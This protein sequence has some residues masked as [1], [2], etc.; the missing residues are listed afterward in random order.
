[1]KIFLTGASGFIGSNLAAKLAR[2]NHQVT[3]LL[4]DHS[5]A[6]EY[7]SMGLKIIYGDLSNK[8]K[9]KA[10]MENCDWVFHLAGYTKPVS[11]DPQL[12]YMTN[13]TGTIN[14][15]EAAREQSV[16]KVIVTSTA[17]TLGYSLNGIP[18]DETV[19]NNPHYNTEYERTKAFSEKTALDYNSDDLE[20]V[21]VNPTRVY[22]PGKIT[23][24]N[25]VTRIIKLYG[26]GL[27][28]IIP[29]GGEAIG[30]YVFIDDVV[31]G[32]LLAAMYGKGG[33]RYLLG[34]ENI[35]YNDF[36]STLGDLYNRKRKLVRLKEPS[37]KRIVKMAGIYSRI[38]NKPAMITEE[39]IDKYL[40]NW[41]VSSDKAKTRLNYEITSFREGAGK[42]ISW[43]R[44]NKK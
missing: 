9:L 31:R 13:V 24:S 14:V 36:F 23:L 21:A 40:R 33:E 15:I 3:I 28:R 32:H 19:T 17:G 29:G 1:M 25:S 30:N 18:V 37:L 5:K 35:S 8:E 27:W 43:I 34:G 7:L 11:K 22:G 20:V 26:K 2:E 41:I 39:W 10:G 6:E 12:P 44:S 4:R 16:K 38:M 42:T